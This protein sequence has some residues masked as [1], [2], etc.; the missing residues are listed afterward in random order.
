MRLEISKMNTYWSSTFG[1]GGINYNA[2]RQGVPNSEPS[3]IRNYWGKGS[4]M[5]PVVSNS[6][7]LYFLSSAGSASKSYPLLSMGLDTGGIKWQVNLPKIHDLLPMQRVNENYIVASDSLFTV[8]GEIVVNFSDILSGENIEYDRPFFLGKRYVLRLPNFSEN[9]NRY[10]LFDLKIRNHTFITLPVV[11]AKLVEGSDLVYGLKKQNDG[12]Y[13]TTCCTIDGKILWETEIPLGASMVGEHFMQLSPENIGVYSKESGELLC[14]VH[15]MENQ[16]TSDSLSSLHH[17]SYSKDTINIISNGDL[18]VFSIFED[19]L[20]FKIDG[21]RIQSHCVAGDLIFTCQEQKR[22]VAYDR[23]S[24][25]EVWRYSERYLWETV[26]ASNN[27]LIAHCAS[28]DIVCF[29]CGEPYISPNRMRL[30]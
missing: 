23:Y 27:K 5:N 20:L 13:L 28:G 3:W 26:I 17:K 4:Y 1:V 30:I 6:D 8:G 29:D 11:G 9:P 2:A 18:Y 24:G 10:F 7:S 15:S 19:R 22:L 14:R 25:D 16:F 12:S 21:C